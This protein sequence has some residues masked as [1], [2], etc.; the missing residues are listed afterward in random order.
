VS[1]INPL[2]RKSAIESW[3][4]AADQQLAKLREIRSFEWIRHDDPKDCTRRDTLKIQPS[5]DALRAFLIAD[6]ER[7]IALRQN[8]LRRTRFE[9]AQYLREQLASLDAEIGSAARRHFDGETP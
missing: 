1:D 6:L 4:R 2:E 3:L 9:A 8:E 5:V 7:Q